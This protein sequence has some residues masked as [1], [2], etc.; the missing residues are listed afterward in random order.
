VRPSV[1]INQPLV[2]STNLLIIKFMV[3]P[4]Q[5]QGLVQKEHGGAI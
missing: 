1:D 5:C 4:S 2:L 3:H